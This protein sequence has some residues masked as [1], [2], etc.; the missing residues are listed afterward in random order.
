MPSAIWGNGDNRH[1]SRSPRAS[2]ARAH[3]YP[4]RRGADYSEQIGR[5]LASE[6][7]QPRAVDVHAQNRQAAKERITMV[8]KQ[9]FLNEALA[10]FAEYNNANS[11][12]ARAELVQAQ[13]QIEMVELLKR[14]AFALETLVDKAE[15]S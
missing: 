15:Q 4:H 9:G 6:F 3:P 12:T 2:V 7:G 11:A 14:I 8:N 10:L 13:A 1:R 5:Y